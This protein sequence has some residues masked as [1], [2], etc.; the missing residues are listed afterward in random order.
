MIANNDSAARAAVDDDDSS[1]ANDEKCKPSEEFLN[2]N[3][4]DVSR[5]SPCD[6][7]LE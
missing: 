3:L 5:G 1:V 7:S 2:L 4:Q 6:L